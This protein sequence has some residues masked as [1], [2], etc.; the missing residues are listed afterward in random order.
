M[1]TETR[2]LTTSFRAEKRGDKQFVIS[3]YAAVFDSPADI[4]GQFT[5]IVQ[6]GAFS[7][8]LREKQNVRIL[9]NHDS[10]KVLAT[11]RAGT[12]TVTQD[13]HGLFVQAQ[14]DPSISWHQDAFRSI[15]RGDVNGMSYGFVVDNDGQK[16][17]TRAGKTYRTLVDIKQLLDCSPVTYPAGSDTTLSARGAG[18]DGRALDEYHRKRLREIEVEI[19]L[20]APGYRYTTDERGQPCVRAMTQSE[21]DARADAANLI[22][23]GLI[24]REIARDKAKEEIEAVKRE[25]GL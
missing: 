20:N 21:V 18:A 12:A 6:P 17:E 10:A 14:L 22:R 8:A 4:G 2:N 11:T 24:A 25:I 3:G 5:E 7:R 15:V 19:L 9:W 16:W 1:K 13:K 23:A